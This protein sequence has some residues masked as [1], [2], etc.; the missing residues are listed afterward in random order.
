[1]SAP[2]CVLTGATGGIGQAIARLLAKQGWRLLLVGRDHAQ[3]SKLQGQCENDA[4]I[5]VGDLN[6]L[7]TRTQLADFAKQLGGAALLVNN[8]GVNV[9]QGFNEISEHQID[10]L[11]AINLI[12]PI[13]LCQLFLPQITA[14]SG[15]IVNVGSSFGSIGYPYQTLYCASKFGLRGMTE[16]LA[17]E[18]SHSK[19]RVL[20]LAPRA[21]DTAINSP[22]VRAMNKALGNTMDPPEKVAQALS[23]LINSTNRRRFIGFEE[24]LFARING[25]F[26]SLV[27]NAIA[28]QLPKIKSFFV[29]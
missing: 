2:I 13:K 18:L 1:M 8:A 24:T 28:K 12:V 3:L 25:M 19:V 27:D 16:A 20:Y 5:F 21:T 14:H 7:E 11:L 26:P 10:Q 6:L 9:M 23:D 4:E 29:N 22:Q 15:T 17:R